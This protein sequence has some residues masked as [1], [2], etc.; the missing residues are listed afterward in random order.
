MSTITNDITEDN[1]DFDD[2]IFTPKPSRMSSILSPTI[3]DRQP[4]LIPPTD[5]NFIID[6]P[7]EVSI[8]PQSNIFI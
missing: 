3:S 5:E 7:S 2:I 4:S 6:P 8:E 1:D